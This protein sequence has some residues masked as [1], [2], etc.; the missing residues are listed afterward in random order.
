MSRLQVDYLSIP[1]RQLVPYLKNVNTTNAELNYAK[2]LLLNWD[3]TLGK[4]SIA[5]AIYVAWEKNIIQQAHLLFVPEK[6]REVIKSIWLKKIISWIKVDRP[7]LKGRDQFLEICLTDALTQLH[8]KLGD[9]I[10]QWHYGQEAYHHARIKHLLSNVVNDSLRKVL[11]CGPLPRGGSGFTVGATSNNDNQS[12]G[13]TF[14]MIADVADWD[15]T[16][17]SNAPGQ[18]G[19]VGSPFYRNL[20][21]DWANDKLFTVYFTQSIIEQRAVETIHLKPK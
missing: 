17:F 18:S 4:N 12:S 6:A 3:Y 15:K 10:N 19:D 1:A 20:F 9:D 5:A 11:E 8:T 7:E 21:V 14:K 13:A 16:L 2:D